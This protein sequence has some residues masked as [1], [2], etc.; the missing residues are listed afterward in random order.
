MKTVHFEALLQIFMNLM[1]FLGLLYTL[2]QKEN[3]KIGQGYREIEPM[4]LTLKEL[5]ESK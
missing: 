2:I 5:S 3:S 1:A 4:V